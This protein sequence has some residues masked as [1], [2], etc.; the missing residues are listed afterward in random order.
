MVIHIV[1]L[2]VQKDK[3]TN[4]A[5]NVMRGSSCVCVCVLAL[6]AEV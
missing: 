3:L 6:T 5:L 4:K 1:D 2:Q